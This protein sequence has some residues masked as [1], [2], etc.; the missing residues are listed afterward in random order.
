MPLARWL[1]GSRSRSGAVTA[2]DHHSLVT[3]PFLTSYYGQGGATPVVDP[4]P[5]VTTRD[6]HALVEPAVEVDDCGFRMLEPHEIQRAMAFADEYIVTGNKRERVR[7]LGNAVTP[8][9][10]RMIL[11]RCLE[12]LA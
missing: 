5:T 1:I 8:P 12:T 11:E 4:V 3:L 2:V 6:R 10:M 7:Q 9:V